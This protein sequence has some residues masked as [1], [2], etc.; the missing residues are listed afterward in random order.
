MTA[1]PSER[2]VAV[3]AVFADEAQALRISREM[4]ERRLAACANVLGPCRS[5][6]RWQ[7]SVEEAKEVAVILKTAEATRDALIGAIAAE[8][9][10][11]VPA[12]VALPVCAAHP[13][14]ARWVEDN[15]AG[16]AEAD[17]VI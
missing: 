7:G 4:V 15:S 3:Y 11:E 13:L 10:Y 5:V 1:R 6:Y 14:Y 9:D 8:H 17:K 16:A 12:I 2:I